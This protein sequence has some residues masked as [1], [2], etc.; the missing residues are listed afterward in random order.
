[1]PVTTYVENGCLVGYHPPTGL[2][3]RVPLRE[4]FVEAGADLDEAELGAL[5][6]LAGGET[7]VGA[8]EAYAPEIGAD[9]EI[10]ASK[11][12]KR[13]AKRKKRRAKIKKGLKKAVKKIAKSKI[14]KGI[15]KIAAKVVPAPFNAPI[16]A[17][18]G[19]AKFARALKKKNPKAKKLKAAVQKAAAGKISAKQLAAQAKKLGVSPKIVTDAAAVKRL[20]MDAKTN[21]RAKAALR[22]AADLTSTNPIKQQLALAAAAQAQAGPNARAFVVQAPGGQ[23]YRTLVQSGS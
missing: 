6:E 23:T 20:A 12:K 11:K 18:Q 16:L 15:A 17:A 21:P 14:L 13:K 2:E 8:L 10:G 3:T 22:L 4:I 19:A 1:M 7:I 5:D 9:L